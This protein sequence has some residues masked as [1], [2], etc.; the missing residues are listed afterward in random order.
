MRLQPVDSLSLTRTSLVEYFLFGIRLTHGIA[1]MLPGLL[2]MLLTKESRVDAPESYLA[3]MLFFGFVGVLVFQ[4]MGIYSEALFSNDLRMGTIAL[5]WSAAFGLLLFMQQALGMFGYLTREELIIWYLGSLA[6]FGI[7]RLLLLMLFKHQ[8]R[9]GVFLQHAVI[10]GATENGQR[11]A[12]YLLEH[13]DIRSGV[14]GFIDDRIGRMP[15]TVA[16]LPMLGNTSDLERLIREEK[17]TQ[18]LVALPWTAENRMDYIIRELRRLPVNVL[19]VPDMI[20][21][22]HTHN[23][24]TEVA[25]LPMFNASEVPLNGWSPF[26]KRAE[27]IV[28]SSLALLALSPV[29]LLVALAIKL[30]SPGP[31]LFRQKR[32]GYNNRLIEVFKFRSMHQHQADATAEQQTTRGDARIT[33]VGR[34]IRKTSL[35]ELPQLFNVVAGSMSM[36]GPRPH[37][38]ATKAAGILFEQAVKEYTSRHRVK[39]GITGLAQINGYRGETDTVEKIEKRVEFDLEYIENWSVWFDLYI[40]MRTVPAVIFTREAY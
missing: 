20:A 27:D 11:L 6:L 22:R 17:V 30:D 9:K 40:L 13:Q 32:Y 21:F 37:A 7:T 25:R 31:V 14:T 8:M 19:L 26:I 36:V 10:L 4:A 5:A 29:M 15:K 34:F 16:N 1:C 3:I 38:T 39:P 12:E 35:D 28:L 24:I 23:R 33:R 18:V 2:I